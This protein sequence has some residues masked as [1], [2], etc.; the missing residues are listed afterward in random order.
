MFVRIL[1]VLVTLAVLGPAPAGADVLIT[2]KSM[3]LNPTA[4][5]QPGPE[6]SSSTWVGQ[7]K[8]SQRSGHVSMIVAL[9]AKKIYVVDHGEQS[10]S[11]LDLPIDFSA[12]SP[13]AAQMI[14]QY[15]DQM[16]LEVSVTPTDEKQTVA[17]YPC[18]KYLMDLQ[19][20][21]GLR[22]NITLWIT[23]ELGIDVGDWKKMTVE[24]AG[25]QPGAASL[26]EKMMAIEG[27]PVSQESKVSM[28]GN[29]MVTREEL[30]SIEEKEPPAGI[31]TPPEGYTL[32]P[33]NPLDGMAGR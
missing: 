24:M 14:E 16:K 11:A 19:N 7:G 6:Q 1:A 32:K 26:A 17:G 9:D 22:M 23:T 30:V 33:F 3:K 4:P 8:L 21:M 5:N 31:Y 29:E 15:M 27:F 28:M 18:T 10:Y 2:R 12:F 25:L 20:A 13:E